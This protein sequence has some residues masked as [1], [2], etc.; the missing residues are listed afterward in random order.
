MEDHL[1]PELLS[2]D[3]FVDCKEENKS[4]WIVAHDKA[5]LL[6][7]SSTNSA[8][9]SGF[10][11]KPPE[12]SIGSA[13]ND[14]LFMVE[15]DPARLISN[16]DLYAEDINLDFKSHVIR[17]RTYDIFITYD[18]YYQVPRLWLQGYD[19]SGVPL[20][21]EQV[22]EDIS[23]EHARKTITMEPH[24]NLP[25]VMAS[26]HPC[27]HA[28]VMKKMMEVLEQEGQTKSNF[29]VEQYLVLFLKFI[30]SVVP[31]IEYDY[32]MPLE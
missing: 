17:T 21:P 5:N 19:E 16:E 7:R 32:T 18:K 14:D 27:K 31:T 1:L 3:E 8:A 30:A 13:S 22:F 15:P 4:D 10:S 28:N 23:Q 25:S 26:I 29:T 20:K 24:P 11:N 6:R 12:G 9:S 2:D